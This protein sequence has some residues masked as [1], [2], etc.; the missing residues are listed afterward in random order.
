MSE[1]RWVSA[2][3]VIV[4][5]GPVGLALAMTLGKAGVSCMLVERQLEP[6]AIPRGQNLSARS[7]EHFYYWDCADELRAAAFQA[8]ATDLGMPPQ[9]IADTLDGQ[10]AAY[11]QR[12]ILVRP[13]QYVAWTGNNPPADTTAVLRRAIGA[14]AS[15]AARVGTSPTRS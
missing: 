1:S 10:R 5:G 2:P 7:L 4:G 9:V 11:G 15:Q 3:V 6:S 14:T 8:A 12:L 13:D